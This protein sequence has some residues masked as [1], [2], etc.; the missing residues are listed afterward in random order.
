MN[1]Q[2]NSN[3]STSISHHSSSL[4]LVANVADSF[5]D[6]Q[7]ACMSSGSQYACNHEDEC[8]LLRTR[9]CC[10]ARAQ[11]TQQQGHL[12]LW[13]FEPHLFPL[14]VGKPCIL[15]CTEN[16]APFPCSDCHSAHSAATRMLSRGETDACMPTQFPQ[17][18]PVCRLSKVRELSLPQKRCVHP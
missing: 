2:T 10:T 9:D 16:K 3:A 12:N 1:M 8:Q 6:T 5:S 17:Q 18:G 13:D 14:P 11:C 7:K 4:T 15:W